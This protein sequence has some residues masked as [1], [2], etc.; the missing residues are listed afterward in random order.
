VREPDGLAAGVRNSGLTG[1]Q[2]QG[3]LAFSQALRRAKEMADSGICS[4][5]RLIAEVTHILSQ[6][7][8]VRVIY[9]SIVD[10]RTME[11]VREVAPGETLLAI[12]AWI[13]E[14]RFIDNAIL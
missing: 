14:V 12:A 1:N 9:V 2:R 10:R 11:A 5:D 3:A 8:S 6:H 7:R 4:P 13:N